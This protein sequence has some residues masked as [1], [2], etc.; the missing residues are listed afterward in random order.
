[1]K[2][3]E[4]LKGIRINLQL[5][6]AHEKQVRYASLV[7]AKLRAT[8]VTKDNFIFNTNFD[9]NPAAGSVKI[10]V[11]DTEVEV[12]DYNTSTGA[13]LT[14]GSTT[15][16]TLIIDK[17]KAVNE[18]CDGYIATAVPDG[19][20][21]ERLDS[22]GYSMALQ[23]EKDSIAVLEDTSKVTKLPTVT[24]LTKTTVYDAIVDAGVALDDANV[25]QVGRYLIVSPEVHGL[26]LKDTT[27]FIRQGD[28]SQELIMRGVIGQIAGFDVY[29]SSVLMKGNTIV[30]PSKTTST[31]FIAGHPQWCHRVV[32][33][34]VE[35]EIKD[36]TNDYIGSSAVQGRYVYGVDVSR[37]TAVLLKRKEL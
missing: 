26:L 31:E 2:R 9:G 35:P 1:M 4:G 24:A 23:I 25:P 5:F 21:A 37:Q 12:K 17:D 18:I 33:F 15:Y 29:K 10:P 8:L 32:D 16:K 13:G 22:A 14:E 3:L 19:L 36:L 30:V 11:R 27:N 7:L 28:L 6:A 34:K 20:L